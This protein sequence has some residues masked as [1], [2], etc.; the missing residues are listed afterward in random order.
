MALLGTAPISLEEKI[1]F[2]RIFGFKIYENYG[3]SETNFI[4]VEI[5]SFKKYR[6]EGSVGSVLPYVDINLKNN[7]YKSKEISIKSPFLF[8]GYLE[9]N[10]RINSK[11]KHNK[12]FATGDIGE[13]IKNNLV[14]KGRS[15]EIIK[16]GGYLIQL[17]EIEEVL[18]GIKELNEI[19]AEDIVIDVIS[20]ENDEDSYTYLVQKTGI[21]IDEVPSK[22]NS[23]LMLEDVW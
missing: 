9:K 20:N 11:L 5:D 8:L 4:S 12:F 3:L 10:G 2:E 15:R 23:R 22:K 14:L 17:R 16:K 13:I 19:V 18:K 21:P 1:N 6:T 7:S